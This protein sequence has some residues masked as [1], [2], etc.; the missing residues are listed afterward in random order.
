MNAPMYY[1]FFALHSLAGE[2]QYK[3]RCI[4][5]PFEARSEDEAWER[6]E[7][8]LTERGI[9]EIAEPS[10]VACEYES[11]R[12]QA[13]RVIWEGMAQRLQAKGI[14]MRLRDRLTGQTILTVSATN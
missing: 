8:M 12:D 1:L 14:G 7:A 6:V 13:Q 4:F 5:F 2:G 10:L 3:T 11:D 9:G